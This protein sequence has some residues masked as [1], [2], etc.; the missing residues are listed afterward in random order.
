MKRTALL[1]KIRGAADEKGVVFELKRQG[2]EHE[3]WLCGRRL[4]AVPR[5]REVAEP[6]ARRI[7]KDLQSEFG[8]GWWR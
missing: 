3:Q 5:H 7:L 2:S 6:T 8:E 4:I 1:R